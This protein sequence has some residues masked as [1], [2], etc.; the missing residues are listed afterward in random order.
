MGRRRDYD[1]GY[2][3]ARRDM[4]DRE[5]GSRRSSDGAFTAAVFIKYAAISS[6]SC[7][8]S[9]T[10]YSGSSAPSREW[11]RARLGSCLLPNRA[12]QP[13]SFF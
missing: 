1:E 12:F 7:S 6:S 9:P 13:V 3:D 2:E 10:W 11:Y 4:M 5:T 8:S